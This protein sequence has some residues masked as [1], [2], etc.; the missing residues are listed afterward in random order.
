VRGV[1]SGL[2]LAASLF[3][4]EEKTAALGNGKSVFLWVPCRDTYFVF[5]DLLD[6]VLFVLF[7]LLFAFGTIG[8][9]RF[10]KIKLW[11]L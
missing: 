10:F 9:A 5:S 3:S 1:R 7:C 8:L 6:Q 11:L 2:I 4:E